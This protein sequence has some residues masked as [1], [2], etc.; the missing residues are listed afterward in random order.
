M[1][2]EAEQVEIVW[3]ADQTELTECGGG[4]K[5]AGRQTARPLRR[6]PQRRVP[7]STIQIPDPALP[8]NAAVA[9]LVKHVTLVLPQS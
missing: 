3:K 2:T 4:W 1:I 9:A 7:L 8:L 5:Q 6:G